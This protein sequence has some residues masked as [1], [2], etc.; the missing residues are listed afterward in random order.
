MGTEQR[1]GNPQVGCVADH[2]IDARTQAEAAPDEHTEMRCRPA[3]QSLITDVSSSVPSSARSIQSL[4][5]V[6]DRRPVELH[7]S[8]LTWD[9]RDLQVGALIFDSVVVRR[10]LSGD[11]ALQELA[12][13]VAFT[14]IA[15]DDY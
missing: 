10:D 1:Q 11:V 2:K 7:A 12:H 14:R 8:C 4:P 3:N 5:P 6:I 15:H 13:E 9:I